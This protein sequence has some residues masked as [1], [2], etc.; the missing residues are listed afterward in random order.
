MR[1]CIDADT[2]RVATN[3]FMSPCSDRNAQLA[4]VQRGQSHLKALKP[5]LVE[6]RSQVALG[7][8]VSESDAPASNAV[9]ASFLNS[10]IPF[11]LVAIENE[12]LLPLPTLFPPPISS[13]MLPRETPLTWLFSL[14]GAGVARARQPPSPRCRAPP[15]TSR[16]S[17]PSI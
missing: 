10:Q 13:I 6:A 16:P 7:K 14:L 11:N 9:I 1:A 5:A 3:P 8:V 12:G 2:Q 17:T 4:S 15:E